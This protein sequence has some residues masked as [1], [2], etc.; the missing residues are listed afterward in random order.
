LAFESALEEASKD[1]HG[2]L[3]SGG[4]TN[5]NMDFGIVPTDVRQTKAFSLTAP[6]RDSAVK[7]VNATIT[8]SRDTQ[9]AGLRLLHEQRSDWL[10]L[11]LNYQYLAPSVF[12]KLI[13]YKSM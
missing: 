10:F 12:A 11:G 4:D 13:L 1:K 6:N 3:V 5:G 9:Y 7:L 2:V 8:G